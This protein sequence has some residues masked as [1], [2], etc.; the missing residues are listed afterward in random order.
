MIAMSNT[1]R[2]TLEDRR[3][4]MDVIVG[5]AIVEGC[6][7][8]TVRHEGIAYRAC[9]YRAYRPGSDCTELGWSGFVE[10][11]TE[12]IGHTGWHEWANDAVKAA[13]NLIRGAS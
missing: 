3:T 1:L 10:S 13:C 6:S 12:L 11:P 9:I 5:K 7:N 4:T 2:V 8:V